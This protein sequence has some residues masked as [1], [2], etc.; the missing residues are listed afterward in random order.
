[1]PNTTPPTEGSLAQTDSPE[2]NGHETAQAALLA[3]PVAQPAPITAKP[4]RVE[5]AQRFS[6]ITIGLFCALLTGLLLRVS[7]AE[8]LSSHV[9]E[10]ASV[11]AAQMVADKGVPVFPSGT[12]YLQGATISYLLAPVIKLGYGGLEHLTTLRM[13]SVI[14]GTLAIL[15]VFYLTRWLT[16]SPLTALG[17]AALLAIDPASVRWGG[18]VRMY[19][20]LQLVSLIMIFLFLKLLRAP[21]TRRMV[22]GFIAVF[23]FGVFTHI[24]IC[25]FLPPMLILAIWKHRMA[26]LNRRLDLSIALAG[27][28]AAPFTLLVLNRL[29]TPQQATPSGTSSGVS[30]VGDYLLSAD[31]ILHPSLKSWRLLFSYD[32]SGGIIPYLLVGLCCILFGRY[33]L[34]RNLP[35]RKLRRRNV[36]AILMTLYWVPILLVAA[37]A[38]ENNERYLLHLHPLGLILIGFAVQELVLG[39]RARPVPSFAPATSPA[40]AIP[41]SPI[42]AVGERF[43]P[44]LQ[45]LTPARI[46]AAAVAATIGVGAVLRLWGYNRLSLWLDEGFSLLYSKQE[47]A[48]AAGFHGFYSPHPPLYFTL[49]KVFNIVLPDAWAGRTVAV[50]C[51]VLVLPV[52]YML[53]RRLL[54]PIAALIATGVFALSPIHIY[55]SQESRMYALVVLSVTASFLAL[56]GFIQTHQRG[57]AV[58]YGISL[59]VAVYADYSSLFVLGPQA[60]ILLYFVWRERRAMLPMVIAAGLAV[61][62]YLPWL[63]Q[64]WSSVNSAN[65]DERRSDYLGAGFKRILIIVLR[66]TG[67]SSDERGAYFPSLKET[68]WDQ[69]HAL[70]PVILLLMAPV[71]VLGVVGLWQRWTAMAVAFSFLGCIGVAVVISLL[72]PGFAERTILCAAV[73]W[74]LLLGA[75]FNGRINRQRTPVAAVSL[76]VVLVLCLGT[77]QNIH[78]SAVKQR[79]NDASADLATVS[80]LN[81]P[82]VTFSYGAVADTLVEA[83]EPGLLDTMRLITVRDGE[84]E[85]TL[86]NDTIPQKGITIADVDAG[87]LDELLPQT[88]DNDVIWYLYYQRRGE[89]FVRAGIENAG[90]LRIIDKVYDAP[91]G[92]VFLDLYAR[93]GANLGDVV[94]GMQPFSNETAWGIPTGLSP[95][96]PTE[97]GTAVH[98]TNQSRTGTA[99]VTQ[100]KTGGA[101]LYTLDV[102]VQTRLTGGRALVTLTCQT[103]AGGVL[104]EL[105]A[106]TSGE[107][108]NDVMHHQSAIFCPADTDQVRITL[109]NLG[110]GEMTFINPSLRKIQIPPRP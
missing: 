48:A 11:M 97:D 83:Y 110:N 61:L 66:I 3:E 73:G 39:E 15:A 56:V 65:E 88:P 81:Y 50:L 9:D 58:L 37:F 51:G 102:D 23:W 33:V 24:A 54:D 29:V 101:A 90:Y 27:A 63:P 106:G 108:V 79:W 28:C 104:S 10:S 4:I 72:S 57:W 91:R 103:Q 7:A 107:R 84:L 19:A 89:E 43:V 95:V 62:A 71:V 22:I 49:I 85:K 109:R 16:Q 82:V 30:F 26:L 38:N 75:A 20:L 25:L 35:A 67:I 40:F 6:L 60:L 100:I 14:A 46:Y 36:F 32:T 87:K 53:A 44:S 18:M 98:I 21:G 80:T 77:I 34:D 47:W 31:Q 52:F 8:R 76:L 99:V 105:T 78:A 74:S 13:L 93:P 96:E 92:L 55:Y 5:H 41:G 68:P 42:E 86:S 59:A 1:M 94:P 64:V 2:T 17:V 69:L 45:W 70:Q 12:L